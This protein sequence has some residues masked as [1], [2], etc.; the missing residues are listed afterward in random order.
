VNEKIIITLAIVI[1]IAFGITIATYVFVQTPNEI[2]DNKNNKFGATDEI[3]SM[4]E[5]IEGDRM[6]NQQSE[7]PYKPKEREW[8]SSG[9]FKLDRSEYVLGERLFLNLDYLDKNTKGEMIFTKIINN[10]HTYQYKKIQ[11][12]GS[13]PQYNFY[14]GLNLNN[15]R[16]LCNAD[17]LIGNWELRFEGT[18]YE[19]IKFKVLDQILP[20][21]EKL[22]EP[23]C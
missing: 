14:I 8:V 20:G 10:T 18:N 12:D 9:P 19:S 6:E 1:A 7:N 15:P 2:E 22:Y 23:V 17:Q 13:K 4:L 21:S 16:G 3:G 11:F 5:K